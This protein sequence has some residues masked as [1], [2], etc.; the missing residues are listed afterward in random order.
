MQSTLSALSGGG[1]WGWGR[2][3][4]GQALSSLCVGWPGGSLPLPLNGGR[5]TFGVSAS[6][7]VNIYD[8][9]FCFVFLNYVEGTV[10]PHSKKVPF[11]T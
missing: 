2:E 3:G 5:E 7:L 10:H 6:G 8:V 1:G 4:L 11:K 9:L